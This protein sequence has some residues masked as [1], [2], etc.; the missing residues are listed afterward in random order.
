MSFLKKFGQV[1][2]KVVGLA[3]GFEPMLQPLLGTL[4][5]KVSAIEQTVV[6]DLTKIA[7]VIGTAEAMIGA[8]NDPNA[9]TGA[10]KLKAATPFVAQ[11]VQSTE[12]MLGKKIHDTALFAQGCTKITDGM[13]D[14]LNSITA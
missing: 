4:G 12:F 2:L 1:I 10:D 8:I 14:V 9:K 13:A 7:G 5:S 6:G 3:S 11:V